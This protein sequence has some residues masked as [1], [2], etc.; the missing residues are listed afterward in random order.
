[1]TTILLARHGE[2]DWN[3]SQRWQ[4]FADRPLTDLGRR[5]AAELAARLEETE[6]DTIYSSDLQRARETAEVVARSKGLE[7][8]ATP[9]LREVDVGSWSGLT[10]A[11]AEAQFPKGYVRWLRGGEGWEDGETYEQMSERVV[12]AVQRIAE[13]HDD[14]R[15]LVVAHGGSIRAVHAAALGLDVHSYRRIQRVEPNATLS[16]VCVEHG[17]FSELCGTEDLDEFL[18]RDQERRREA[19][20]RPP[21]PAG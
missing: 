14:G 17:R 1:M 6:L 5:Q 7:V 16:A 11:E 19:A 8:H 15:V 13:L 18:I 4:G 10:R 9:D 12:A 2:S 21:A 20:L 3:R